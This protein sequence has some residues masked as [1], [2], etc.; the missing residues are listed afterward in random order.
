M[1]ANEITWNFIAD[2]ISIMADDG[3]IKKYTQDQAEA[4]VADTGRIA[5]LAVLNWPSD[6]PKKHDNPEDYITKQS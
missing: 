3:T 4:Y 2:T 1:E 6:F 5:D